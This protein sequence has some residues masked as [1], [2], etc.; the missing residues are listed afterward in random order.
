MSN[1]YHQ[2]MH[3]HHHHHH[4]TQDHHCYHYHHH[5]HRPHHP[6]LFLD[7]DLSAI[8]GNLH[9]ITVIVKQITAR[10]TI[11]RT[12]TNKLYIIMPGCGCR[13]KFV[14]S[15]RSHSFTADATKLQLPS[16]SSLLTPLLHFA[17]RIS[18]MVRVCWRP[19][20]IYQHLWPY[21]HVHTQKLLFSSFR[22][23]FLYHHNIQRPRFAE[24]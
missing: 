4:Q 2:H 17:T 7:V 3:H 10:T 19:Q 20:G 8:S 1:H 9:Y 21:F 6:D 15:I 24:K 16:F 11:V 18:Y 14:F 23:K 5:H 13:I 12:T 22:L